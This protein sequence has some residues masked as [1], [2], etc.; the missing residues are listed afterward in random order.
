MS[1]RAMKRCKGVVVTEDGKSYLT[2]WRATPQG[3]LSAAKRLAERKGLK[4]KSING[5]F[6][7]K[8]SEA[9]RDIEI[10]ASEPVG[11]DHG[12]SRHLRGAQ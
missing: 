1:R 2:D 9:E 7:T 5:L 4:V 3:A 6:L 10:T 11:G 8:A 12:H